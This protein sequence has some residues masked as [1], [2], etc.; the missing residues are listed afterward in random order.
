MENWT[1]FPL[2]FVMQHDFKSM[3][4]TPFQDIVLKMVGGGL[5][6]TDFGI[7]I[8]LLSETEEHTHALSAYI[9]Q[10]YFFLM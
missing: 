3:I 1:E 7:C 4:Y 9:K 2:K 6:N 8:W 10:V 5:L